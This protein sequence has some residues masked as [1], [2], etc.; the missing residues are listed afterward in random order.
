M[1][2]IDGQLV[3]ESRVD[4]HA[5]VGGQWRCTFALVGLCALISSAASL[6]SPAL[7]WAGESYTEMLERQAKEW[8]KQEQREAAR[9]AMWQ[10][11]QAKKR[12]AVQKASAEL[13]E[14][15]TGRTRASDGAYGGVARSEWTRRWR[16]A[17]AALEAAEKELEAFP[18]EARRAGVPPGWLREPDYRNDSEQRRGPD[19]SDQ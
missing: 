19:E 5:R 6:L 9:K 1:V 16:N 12:Y 13:R 10:R 7:A 3:G 11:R 17:Q 15:G 14:A 18:E 4:R 8:E 2:A